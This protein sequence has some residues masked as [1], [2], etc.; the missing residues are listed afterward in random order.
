M[1]PTEAEA[2]AQTIAAIDRATD[3]LAMFA[4]S[5]EP[6]LGVTEIATA[7]NL[8]K[9]VVY[10]ILSSFRAKGFVE[11]DESTRRYS[12]G[13]RVLHLG[14]SYLRRTDVQRLARPHLER[15]SRES[16]ETATLSVRTDG[17]RVYVD[18]VT[19][20]R[21]VKMVVQLGLAVPLHAGA[22]SKAFLA[23]LDEEE[24]AAYLD[25]PLAG[26][27]AATVTDPRALRR[28]LDEIR[29]RGYAAS[30]GERMEGAASVAAP[31][32]GF[33]GR[34]VAVISVCGP[35]ERFAGTAER[36]AGLLLDAT[37]Q[38]SHQLGHVPT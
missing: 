8:S 24:Q 13:P 11:L 22:S 36:A 28:E 2:P 12:L 7:L 29:S 35:A 16:D 25:G 1:P 5:P 4:D 23:F 32:F 31:V 17:T 38:L 37:T 19:P 26:L 21:D 30:A 3:V 6:T 27:T 10:R 14:L 34:P 18:Q 15:L 20:V 9:A 33:D